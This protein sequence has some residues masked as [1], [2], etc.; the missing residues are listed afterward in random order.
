MPLKPTCDACLSPMDSWLGLC[1][2]CMAVH[3]PEILAS[4]RDHI[5]EFMDTL[6]PPATMAKYRETGMEPVKALDVGN[7]EGELGFV[8]HGLGRNSNPDVRAAGSLHAWLYRRAEG[9]RMGLREKSGTW[10]P[11]CH[12]GPVSG[13]LDRLREFQSST[14]EEALA[15]ITHSQFTVLTGLGDEYATGWGETALLDFLRERIDGHYWTVLTTG[16][17]PEALLRSYRTH[18]GA[19]V[20]LLT[21]RLRWVRGLK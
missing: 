6:L 2:G 1:E 14:R 11:P 17:T 5:P 12:W 8:F 13:F 7:L 4:R 18:G 19:I 9:T 21:Q 16:S 10:V 15:S 20:D 3:G